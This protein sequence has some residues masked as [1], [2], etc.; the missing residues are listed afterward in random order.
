MDEKFGDPCAKKKAAAPVECGSES[1]AA[2]EF[3]PTSAEAK[4]LASGSD[5]NNPVN[6]D[7]GQDGLKPPPMDSTGDGPAKS[8]L[9][10]ENTSDAEMQPGETVEDYVRR[11]CR[12][13]F[14]NKPLQH[15]QASERIRNLSSDTEKI[16]QARLLLSAA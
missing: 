4:P 14:L 9:T 2:Q 12:T 11:A 1:G 13:S 3:Y 10:S 15:L 5:E 16:E 8:T 7:S 6:G